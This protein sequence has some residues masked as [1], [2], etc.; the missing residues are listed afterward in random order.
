[1]ADI[2]RTITLV[3][4]G[5]DLATGN[6][7]GVG[8]L[9]G[10]LGKVALVAGGAL[11]TGAL[12]AGAAIAKLAI[13][14][15]PLENVK[16]AF[17]GIA[18]SSGKSADAMLAALKRGSAG[19]I[20]Q[21]TLMKSYNQAAG[22]VS[23]TF[24]N[25]LPDA[26]K[27]LGKISA[28]TGQDMGY[29]LDSLVRG[30]GRLSPLIL[31]NLQIQVSLA[32][33]TERASQMFGVAA[34]ELSKE[35]QQAG[36]MAIAMEK[37][38]ANT[39][40]MPDVT[41]SAAAQMAAF[42]ATIADTRAQIGT[43]FL[44]ILR[45]VMGV[46]ASVGE[47]VLPVVT[48]ALDVIAPIV[49]KVAGAFETFVT[50]ILAGA[51]PIA[52]LTVA[53][54]KVFPPEV[55]Q[56]I[57]DAIR[58][59]RDGI[60]AVVDAVAPYIKQAAAWI[61]ENV[62]LGDVLIALGIAITAVVI[63]AIW[64]ILG[65]ILA[66]IGIAAA[67]VA[68]IA[69]LR[70]A[71]VSDFLGIRTALTGA[72]NRIKPILQTL[73]EWL[74]V[75]IPAAIDVLV[76]FWTDTLLPAIKAVWAFVEANFI[77]ILKALGNVVGAV[78]VVAG[79]VLAGLWQNVLLPALKAAGRWIADT[80]GPI[81]EKFL[82]W[83]NKVTGGIDGVKN[84]LKSVRDWLG[85]VAE[86]ISSIHLPSWLTPGSPT[87]LEIGLEGIADAARRLARIE[88]P[89]MGSALN[90]PQFAAAGFANAGAGIFGGAQPAFA[91][92]GGGN[93]Y[94]TIEG[95]VL[96]DRTAGKIADQIARVQRLRGIRR[97]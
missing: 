81:L 31:D 70:K 17:E 33:A 18:T 14:A 74:K 56:P 26:M 61:A 43:A 66:V 15:A 44:P 85:R 55:A 57:I 28:S 11:V 68:G 48:R 60:R 80:F 89:Q 3:V 1:V 35:Q 36:M 54:Y 34:E 86:K 20:T 77:P 71:W 83:L 49:E 10:G 40:A 88:F 51:D 97:Y 64:G 16:A 73:W 46:L 38:K 82:G 45:V 42:K 69:L 30:V 19:M 78:L 53:L 91:G 13:D 23:T 2:T 41:K 62:K 24:A 67:L 50:G 7:K 95:N 22:L 76:A 37:L 12:G 27:Y 87:P 39:A 4:K 63:P 25:Q 84:A 32:E 8:K 92:A 29:M 47:K 21:E 65:P 90:A 79:R 58:N 94:I 93:I 72:W 75:N 6:L 59:V 52:A 96:D 9:L 5:K